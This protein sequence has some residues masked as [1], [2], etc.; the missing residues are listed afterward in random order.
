VGVNYNPAI[1]TNGL[2]MYVDA[3]N[4]KS[5]P[6]TGTAWN[7]LS[8][9]GNNGVLN[10]PT[11]SSSDG[12][13]MV[14]DGVNDSASASSDI[15]NFGTGNFTMSAWI[16]TTVTGYPTAAQQRIFD[17]SSAGQINNPFNILTS[18][19]LNFRV[20]D[21]VNAIDFQVLTSYTIT[22][23]IWHNCLVTRNSN[24]W[25]IYVNGNFITSGTSAVTY[26]W[27]SNTPFTIGYYTEA[28]ASFFKGY[29][30][31][32]MIYKGNGLTA[33]EIQQNFNALRGR[34]GI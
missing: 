30:S 31:N 17:Q 20:I 1:V 27:R 22:P 16:N 29:I 9:N 8:G 33:A 12:G 19:L 21:I 6:G 32:V 4:T 18:G 3:A 34:Y 2:V 28:N 25:S 15:Y 7:D 5:Y 26:P 24:T 11:Y 13:Y 10:G 14:F 23:N